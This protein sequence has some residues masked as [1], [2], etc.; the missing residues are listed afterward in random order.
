M[1]SQVNSLSNFQVRPELIKTGFEPVNDIKIK[2]A[3]VSPFLQAS[4][5]DLSSIRFN[6]PKVAVPQTTTYGL[7]DE[8]EQPTGETVSYDPSDPGSLFSTAE[9]LAKSPSTQDKVKAQELFNKFAELM[10]LA[11]Q[12]L[13]IAHTASMDALRAMSGR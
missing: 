3:I 1:N 13:N 10:Q 9:Q 6:T 8:H 4:A 11:V 12:L 7:H 2:T 5:L